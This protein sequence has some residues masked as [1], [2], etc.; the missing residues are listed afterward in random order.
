MSKKRKKEEKLECI[1]HYEGYENYSLV[2]DV[3]E[4]NEDKIRW[5]RIIREQK[6][7]AN[8]HERQCNN[9]PDVIDSNIHGI[10]VTPCYKKFTLILSTVAKE[11][12]VDCRR[13][14]GDSQA[15]LLF[16]EK[17][18][19]CKKVR[20]KYKSKVAVPNKILTSS[21]ETTIK[22]SAQTKDKELH[23]RIVGVDLI[24][25]EFKYHQVCYRE[26]TRDNLTDRNVNP[27]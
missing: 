13:L 18:Q 11:K 3:S 8:H 19:F 26:F 2:K 9:I 4:T 21:A 6:G 14:S 27:K 16:Q 7:G 23:S 1:I 17:C 22:E 10:H 12:V 25:K 15:S 24:A 5:A 20:I